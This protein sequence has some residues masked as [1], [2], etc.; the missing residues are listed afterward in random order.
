MRDD[1]P[2]HNPDKALWQAVLLLV[3]DDALLGADGPGAQ[4]MRLTR[5]QATVEARTYL[6][7]PSKDL[8][9]VCHLA[10]LD[11]EAVMTSMRKRIAK[12]PSPEELASKPKVQIATAMPKPKAAPKQRR[13][14]TSYTL[15]G[16]TLTVAEWAAHTGISPQTIYGRLQKG[17]PIR[18][19][20][21]KPKNEGKGDAFRQG[22]RK[23]PS[24]SQGSMPEDADSTARTWQ[25]G[26]PAVMLTHNGETLTIKEW[27][28]RTG[29]KV[30]TIKNRRAKGWP[31]ERILDTTDQ[32][33]RQAS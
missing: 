33:R 29:L 9:I 18:D 24:N 28:E 27:A 2:H 31:V 30:N 4:G 6:T 16:L 23:A 19:A 1:D 17:W 15:D 21:T 12:A 8:A 11:P 25:R 5:A 26:S 3:V 32:R 10:G 22:K 20:L 7:T 14:A 13:R